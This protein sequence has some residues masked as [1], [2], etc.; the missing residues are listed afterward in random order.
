MCLMRFVMPSA[1]AVILP[2]RC[3]LLLLSAIALFACLH[4]KHRRAGGTTSSTTT[5]NVAETRQR[6]SR[7]NPQHTHDP[8]PLPPCESPQYTKGV[9]P[10]PA[11]HTT[12]SLQ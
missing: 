10:E 12:P 2:V 7:E 1:L 11:A 4:A 3:L 5:E 8:S 6:A 9:T